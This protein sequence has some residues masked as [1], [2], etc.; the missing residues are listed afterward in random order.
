LIVQGDF[1]LESQI[2]IDHVLIRLTPFI[3][4]YFISL[5][6]AYSALCYIIFMHSCNVFQYFSLS[7]ILV[8][9]PTSL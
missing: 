5:F 7:N 6:K 2:C 4:L 9:S 3:Y 1:A 8:P